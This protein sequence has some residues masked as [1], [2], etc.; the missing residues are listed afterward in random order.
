MKVSQVQHCMHRDQKIYIIDSLLPVDRMNLFAGLRKNLK[1]DNELNKKHVR[2]LW[3][4]DDSI[5]LDVAAPDH[6]KKEVQ[7]NGEE[8][9]RSEN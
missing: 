8:P 6:H 3:A 9:K 7:K 4:S 2:K 1:K 5:V